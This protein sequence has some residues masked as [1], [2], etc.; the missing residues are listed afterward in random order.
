MNFPSALLENMEQ[1]MFDL[2]STK[3]LPMDVLRERIYPD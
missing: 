2:G 3:D 1:Q